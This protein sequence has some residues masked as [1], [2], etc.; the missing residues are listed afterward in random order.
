MHK[1]VHPG[2]LLVV[3]TLLASATLPTQGA[4]G[5][6]ILI[7]EPKQ[8]PI[9]ISQPGSYQLSGNLTVPDV[10]TT[11]I[12][13]ASDN[14]TIDLNG[15]SIIGPFVCSDSSCA[16]PGS[17]YG[18]VTAALQANYSNITVRNGTI[19]GMGKGGIFLDGIGVVVEDMHVAGIA[20]FGIFVQGQNALVRHNNIVMPCNPV[21]AG[22]LT[23]IGI[24]A[25][26]F[27]ISDNIVTGCGQ[28]TGVGNVAA[29]SG[30]VIRNVV[31]NLRFGLFLSS[32]DGYREN[33]LENQLNVLGGINFGQNLC[34]TAACP[35]AVY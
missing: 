12:E 16:S 30:S 5:G 26:G 6:P 17:G 9:T 7:S 22:A 27:L 18:I 15:F 4:G 10:D 11:A 3:A 24:G 8:F 23:G 35:N 34:G 14:V 25:Q 33:V 19:Q 29:I 21:N 32:N 13:I 2:V 1:Q 31:S 20:Y 28:G